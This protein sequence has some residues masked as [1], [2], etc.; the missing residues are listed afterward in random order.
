MA[1]QIGQPCAPPATR[2]AAS[3]S[4]WVIRS[5]HWHYAS[6]YRSLLFTEDFDYTSAVCLK[7]AH[8]ASWSVRQRRCALLKVCYLLF[9]LVARTF[10]RFHYFNCL[11]EGGLTAAHFFF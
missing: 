3:G 11:F 9:D 7:I 4:C 2:H 10:L 5:G 8:T 1:I 6:A